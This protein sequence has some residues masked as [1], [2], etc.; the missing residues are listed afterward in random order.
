MH[1]DLLGPGGKERACGGGGPQPQE[2][3]PHAWGT[4][5]GVGD[6]LSGAEGGRGDFADPGVGA[7]PVYSSA[8]RSAN[9][10]DA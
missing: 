1:P 9:L 4:R 5:V 8:F 3:A 7:S 6:S 2:T 10:G